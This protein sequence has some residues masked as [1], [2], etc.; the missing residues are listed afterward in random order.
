[1]NFQAAVSA[2]AYV[3][4]A[5]GQRLSWLDGLVDD[6]PIA[7]E[8]ETGGAGDDLR[9]SLRLD[10]VVEIQVKRGLQS[11]EDLWSSLTAL[12]KICHSNI[13]VY[14]VLVVSPSSSNTIKTHLANDVIR[15]GQGRS[16]NLSEISK[17]FV[18]RLTALG[19][20]IEESCKRI[21][22]QTISALEWDQASIQAARAELG[23]ICADH[24]QLRSTWDILYKDSSALIEHRGRRDV[25][26]VLA[27]LCASGIN[28]VEK[29]STA[30]MLL[31]EKLVKWTI[32]TSANFSIFGVEKKLQI[33]EAWIPLR[34]I[35]RES[36][37]VVNEDLADAIKSYQAWE[38]RNIPRDAEIIDPETLGRFITRA[39]IIGGPGMGKTTL[40]KRIARRYSEDKIPVMRVR[41]SAVAASMKNG[42]SFENAIFEHGF[43]SSGISITE[44]K[45]VSF[46]NWLLLCDGLDECGRQQENVAEGA[47]RFSAGHPGCTILVTTRPVGY[48]VAHFSEWRHYHLAPLED[49]RTVFHLANLVEEIANEETPQKQN[50]YSICKAAIDE[51]SV[52]KVVSRSPLLLVLAASIVALGESLGTTKAQ[53]YEQ[54]FKLIDS[55]PNGRIPEV[56]GSPAIL[57]RYLNIL[58]WQITKYPL[59]SVA[60]ILKK[61]SE[62]VAND[63]GYT[64]FQAQEKSNEYLQYWQDVGI[65]ERIG[66]GHKDA[67]TFIHK[68]FGEFSAAR[69]LCSMAV[70][71][72]QSTIAN[73]IDNSDWF[74]VLQFSG[75]LGLADVV[76]N[77][78]LS[79]LENSSF[80]SKK[81]L[82]LVELLVE[83]NPAPAR[84]LRKRIVD[85]TFSVVSSNRRSL[86]FE[87]GELLVA[88]ARRFPEEVG[89][90]SN[91]LLDHEQ[92]WTRLVAWSSSVAAG[93]PHY[94]QEQLIE[95]TLFFISKLGSGF[96]P[97]LAGGISLGG[98]GDYDLI[99]T[100]ALD[101]ISEL[102]THSSSQV[103]DQFFKEI[104]DHPL[105][106]EVSFQLNAR[107]VLESNGR[108][109]E[110]K[111]LHNF[112]RHSMHPGPE[113]VEAELLAFN[114]IFDAF[115]LPLASLERKEIPS[116][117]LHFSAFLEA[118]NF[119]NIEMSDTW[120]WTKLYD[121]LVT[122]ETLKGFVGICKINPELLRLEMQV[123]RDYLAVSTD[124][125]DRSL[126]RLITKVDPAEVDW[127][128]AK[129]LG[130]DNAKIE[131]SLYHPSRWIVWLGANL[132]ANMLTASEMNS[133]LCRL[134]KTGEGHALW[135]A[136]AL[137]SCLEADRSIA[138]LLERLSEPHVHG[139]EHLISHLKN[140]NLV[141]DDSLS[142]ISRIGL[143]GDVDIAIETV[144]LI[145]KF[146][147][148][149]HPDQLS[150]IEDALS[151][152]I[153][154]EVPYPKSSGPIPNSPRATLI[155]VL[156]K[157]RP[158]SFQKLK[159]FV[160]DSR[161][162]VRDTAEELLIDSLREGDVS[163]L[164]FLSDI[165]NQVLP[166]N[167]LGKVL[168][169]EVSLNAV[170]INSVVEL[171]ASKNA[172]IRLNAMSVFRDTY[173]NT[174]QIRSYAQMMIQDSENEIRERAYRVIDEL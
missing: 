89:P 101:A 109:L 136:A 51:S 163:I 96:K 62:I 170:E 64:E 121:K 137:T 87:V 65:I 11:G 156:K 52:R 16:D 139:C 112:N 144:T 2:I 47:A 131:S 35:V 171:L 63:F 45:K 129:T 118:S 12:A 71:E 172:K 132:L 169:A 130:L 117:L 105:L 126:F 38:D 103:S 123:A 19:L 40:L 142:K 147:I 141:W 43:D 100:F 168:R 78:L 154:N 20:G 91:S 15:L 134:M 24:D 166:V 113:Y 79:K 80:D 120:A 86:V 157:I 110:L 13:N 21:R 127:S 99:K 4:M 159:I 74:E 49:S 92:Y 39:V 26:S 93:A 155:K 83:A 116:T 119:N 23:H 48:A 10:Q 61:A 25:S 95:V 107:R 162:D 37:D 66:H 174:M 106:R 3:Y 167:L 108:S 9:L 104:L 5:R 151:Y 152:W 149:D 50:A 82:Q 140:F 143:N 173:L 85:A 36:L 53:L 69:Y 160:N 7:V 150:L 88:A 81:I 32:E 41:L 27:L 46:S 98:D 111:E 145:D 68:S 14:G 28:L 102:L 72:Q 164:E 42:S 18:S 76:S 54:I 31:L 135:A 124:L 125:E 22:I 57:Q 133:V 158:L 34:A 153:V 75:L 8:A 56:P 58:G 84:A 94:R 30:P 44:I 115:D 165:S 148:S 128:A 6:T 29:K 77:A 90:A 114:A 59:D 55:V 60:N 67:L 33:D 122:R 70:D 146:V 161:P 97:S 73:I 1:M 138:L 17:T